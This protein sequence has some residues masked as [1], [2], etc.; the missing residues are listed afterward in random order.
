MMPKRMFL[1]VYKRQAK[2]GA[3]AIISLPP[4]KADDATLLAYYKTIGAATDL[5]LVVQSQGN[6][7]SLIHI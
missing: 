4:E 3:D 6:M 7:L 1:D 2:H 5:P